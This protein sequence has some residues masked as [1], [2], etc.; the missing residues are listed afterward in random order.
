MNVEPLMTRNALPL[1]A[2]RRVE[3]PARIMWE[4]DV[5][6]VVVMDGKQRPVG[7]I[8]DRDVATA[9]YTQGVALRDSRVEFAMATHV[10]GFANRRGYSCRSCHDHLVITP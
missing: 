9:A 8:T 2:C 4:A 7:M 10:I 3:Q 5:G 1:L 6:C